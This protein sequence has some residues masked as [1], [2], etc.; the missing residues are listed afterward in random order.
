MWRLTVFSTQ[1]LKRGAAVG[2]GA[3]DGTASDGAARLPIGQAEVWRSL[4]EQ[5]PANWFQPETHAMP[6]TL[7]GVTVQL[8]AVNRELAKYGPGLPST[9]KRWKQYKELTRMRGTLTNQIAS[10]RPSCG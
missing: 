8:A 4:V 5:M 7:C 1:S 10:C 3:G 2:H 9:A 6:E